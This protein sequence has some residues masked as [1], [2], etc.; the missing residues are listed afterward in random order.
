MQTNIKDRY[1]KEIGLP[2]NAILIFFYI[3]ELKNFLQK[4]ILYI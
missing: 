4:N 2:E 1:I 3:Y